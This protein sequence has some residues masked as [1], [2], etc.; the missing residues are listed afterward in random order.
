MTRDRARSSFERLRAYLEAR[1]KLTPVDLTF[2]ESLF[3]PRRLGKGEVLQRAG[4]PPRYQIFVV[5]GCLR[6]Y[7]IDDKGN[8]RTVP[9]IRNRVPEPVPPP[10]VGPPAAK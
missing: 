1:A 4:E 7:V 5:R 8:L 10:V 6:S 2:V 9:P 3:T